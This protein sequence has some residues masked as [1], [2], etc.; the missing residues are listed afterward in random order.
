MRSAERVRLVEVSKN[1]KK[2][3]KNN[4]ILGFSKKR[5]KK[6]PKKASENMAVVPSEALLVGFG[7]E[8]GKTKST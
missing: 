6:W 2:L 8:F 1:H 3:L 4:S 7:L 5:P